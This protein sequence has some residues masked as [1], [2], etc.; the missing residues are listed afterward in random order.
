MT[1]HVIQKRKYRPGL[2]I[3]QKTDKQTQTPCQIDRQSKPVG[4]HST[5]QEVECT[6]LPKPTLIKLGNAFIDCVSK[7]A[8]LDETKQNPGHKVAK[9]LKSA[10]TLATQTF[11]VK[12]RPSQDYYEE[13]MQPRS[14]YGTSGFALGMAALLLL[15]GVFTIQSYWAALLLLLALIIAIFGL[16]RSI[17]GLKDSYEFNRKGKIFSYVGLFAS[18]T[19]LGISAF[20]VFIVLLAIIAL[21]LV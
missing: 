2:Y 19:A 12:C 13:Q 6:T 5:P 18:A 8:I 3:A 11:R 9:G 4:E 21:I 7:L 10:L 1:S 20:L 15:V 16:I 14:S 17:K